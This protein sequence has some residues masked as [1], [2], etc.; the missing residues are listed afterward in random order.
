MKQNYIY[1]AL[2]ALVLL[3]CCLERGHA[4]NTIQISGKVL[5]AADGTA[6]PGATIQVKGTSNG[7][8]ADL[9]GKFELRAVPNATLVFSFLGYQTQELLIGNQ[10]LIEV[11]L[12]SDDKALEEVVVLWPTTSQQDD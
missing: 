10:T 6:L 11:R 12:E 9:D 4:Q 7:T 8:T 2:A 5:A 3:L 1:A